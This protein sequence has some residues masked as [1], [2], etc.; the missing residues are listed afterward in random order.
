MWTITKDEANPCSGGWPWIRRLEFKHADGRY[1]LGSYYFGGD[2]DPSPCVTVFLASG[3]GD[4]GKSWDY[5]RVDPK[6]FL[7]TLNREFA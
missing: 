3:H 6:D 7:D 5:H 2:V 1:A 4:G